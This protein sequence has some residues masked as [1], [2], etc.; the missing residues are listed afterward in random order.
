MI[1]VAKLIMPDFEQGL[2]MKALEWEIS[3]AAS[4]GLEHGRPKLRDIRFRFYDSKLMPYFFDWA[5][6][7]NSKRSGKIEYISSDMGKVEYSFSFE[8]AVCSACNL[9]YNRNEALALCCDVSLSVGLQKQDLVK[10]KGEKARQAVAA[11]IEKV[12][13]N[14]EPKVIKQYITDSNDNEN[15]QYKMGD[16]IYV[17]VE[18]QNMIGEEI[19]L[20]IPDKK[21]DFLYQGKRLEDDT[22]KSYAITSDTEK[23]PLQVIPEDYKDL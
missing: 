4:E 9:H 23:I 10:G 19:D 14:A 18:S 5:K 17:V 22:L 13:E 8:D 20:K 2:E 3:Q 6:S 1:I 16:H 11:P 15:A 12:Q 21:V 7:S